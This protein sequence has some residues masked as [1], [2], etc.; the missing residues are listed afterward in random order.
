MI[1]VG[2]LGAGLIGRVHARAYSQI[3]SARLVAVAD[4]DHGAANQV[5]AEHGARAYY[6]IEAL[7]ADPEIDTVD[8]CLPTYLHEQAVVGA[9]GAG[10]HVLCEKPIARSL[11]EADRMLEAVEGS[12]VTAM[13]A[14]VVRFSPQYVAIKECLERGDL[15]RPLAAV[16][17]RL[18][19]PPNWARWFQ[20]PQL[21]GGAALDLHVHDLDY[22]FHLFGQP[23][24]VFAVGSQSAAG[25]W[26]HVLTT[27]DYGDKAATAE[28]SYMMPTRF[29]FT[30]TFRLLGEKGCI[31]CH[32]LL[33]PGWAGPAERVGIL[34][35]HD[36]DGILGAGY[37]AL[38]A[39]ANGAQVHVIIFCN[40]QAGY[41]TPEA[42]EGIVER[43]RAEAVAA[44][45]RLGVSATHIHRFDYPDFSLAPCV[46]WLLPWGGE[47]TM[48]RHLRLLRQL[49]ITRLLVPNGY[50]EHLD[51]DATYR[52]GT[53]DG[54]QVG[55][56]ILADWGMASPIRSMLQYAVW[57]DLSPE[58]ALVQGHSPSL[59]A[60]RALLASAAV[61][62]LVQE[63]LRAFG[64]QARVIE[65]LLA[66]RQAR[67]HDERWLEVYLAFDARPALDYRPYHSAIQQIEGILRERGA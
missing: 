9:A 49:G 31:E 25:A 41:S 43:R 54:P 28:A 57:G 5:A 11:A 38:A 8:V 63:A 1:R 7:L 15:G 48:G 10:K 47:G 14:Q 18:A 6:A 42:R 29:P 44:Y 37:A 45:R 55:D 13:I 27:L 23:E 22:L 26:D 51:H 20:C 65:G 3:E 34:C 52:I 4:I 62:E 64:S 17:A 33:F 21:S 67:R 36:D 60:N 56:A 46:G 58:D 32:N 24:R 35:P 61:E 19:A 12:G 16:A 53:F 50:R 30:T 2:L 66:A 40:G 59:R 39:L